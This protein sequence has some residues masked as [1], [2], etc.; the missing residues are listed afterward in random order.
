VM[1]A[2]RMPASDAPAMSHTCAAT[3]Q[4]F[5]SDRESARSY[6]AR[7]GLETEMESAD[8]NSAKRWATLA[9]SRSDR[10]EASDPLVRASSRQ[11]DS[12]RSSSALLRSGFESSSAN[13]PSTSPR[14]APEATTPSLLRVR[15]KSASSTSFRGAYPPAWEKAKKSRRASANQSSRA[16]AG[17]PIATRAW[18]PFSSEKQVPMT[19]K[20]AVWLVFGSIR[21]S[22]KGS[23]GVRSPRTQ[24]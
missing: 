9:R 19:S 24:P 15:P 5:P 3:I 17:A 2:V 4:G 7:F 13:V 23:G 6:R 20:T 16:L 18:R 22:G 11:L 1:K 14:W 21:I 10:V 8:S 12:A